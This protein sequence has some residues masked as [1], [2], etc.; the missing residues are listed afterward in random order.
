MSTPEILAGCAR[1]AYSHP[2]TPHVAASRFSLKP[3][4]AFAAVWERLAW[5]RIACFDTRKP[6]GPDCRRA[7]TDDVTITGDL[8]PDPTRLEEKTC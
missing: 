2:R 3:H 5:S 6:H 8:R 7:A 1:Y 4:Q